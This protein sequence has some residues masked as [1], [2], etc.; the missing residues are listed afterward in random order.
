M[1]HIRD[2]SV[3]HQLG[4]ALTSEAATS[5]RSVTL[6]FQLLSTTLTHPLPLVSYGATKLC[7]VCPYHLAREQPLTLQTTAS[8]S[9][10]R[11]GQ[12]RQNPFPCTRA[13]RAEKAKQHPGGLGWGAQPPLKT[14]LQTNPLPQI[15]VTPSAGLLTGG[16]SS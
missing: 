8:L 14:R 9:S 5:P 2:T 7:Y 11:E 13:T 6:G 15:H 16:F 10:R 1:R 4:L 12:R 3:F